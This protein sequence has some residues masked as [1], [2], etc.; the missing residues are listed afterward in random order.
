MCLN[1]CV[2]VCVSDTDYRLHVLQ[3][4]RQCA[5][6]T[7]KKCQSTGLYT[8]KVYNTSS[9][10]TNLCFSLVKFFSIQNW[11]NFYFPWCLSFCEIELSPG[12]KIEKSIVYNYWGPYTCTWSA[13]YFRAKI[14]Y[15]SHGRLREQNLHKYVQRAFIILAYI[16][17]VVWVSNNGSPD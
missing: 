7:D 15:I 17:A 16:K 14:N 6:G 3:W 12:N 5:Q 10:V 11:S 8:F 13:K 9:P 2:C 1:V 4:M